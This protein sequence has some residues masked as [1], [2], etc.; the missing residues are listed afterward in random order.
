[1]TVLTHI[2]L[3]KTWN[4]WINFFTGHNM[5]IYFLGGLSSILSCHDYDYETDN[6]YNNQWNFRQGKDPVTHFTSTLQLLIW[7][8]SPEWMS[9]ESCFHVGKKLLYQSTVLVWVR[10][11]VW[12][13]DNEA[14]IRSKLHSNLARIWLVNYHT[15][16]LTYQFR[17][18]SRS[19]NSLSNVTILAYQKSLNLS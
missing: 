5:I 19:T 17:S 8:T 1:M 15:L 9:P 6:Q 12:E 14:A 7:A 4:M 11:I 10:S 2:I 18:N 13:R 3:W 16:N